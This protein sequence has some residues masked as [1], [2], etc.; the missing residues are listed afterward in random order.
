MPIREEIFSSLFMIENIQILKVRKKSGK[1]ATFNV[2]LRS[3]S[4]YA[5]NFN[6]GH[7]YEATSKFN[8]AFMRTAV[9]SQW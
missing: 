8:W 1:N 6:S 4:K 3:G 7:F 2:M 9:H 5:S